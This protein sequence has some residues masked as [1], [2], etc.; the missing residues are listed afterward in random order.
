MRKRKHTTGGFL[1]PRPG[2]IDPPIDVQ[3]AMLKK[4]KRP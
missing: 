3:R 1:F 2:V 4:G